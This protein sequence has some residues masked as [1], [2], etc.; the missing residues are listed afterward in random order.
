M[1]D[2]FLQSSESTECCRV[3]SASILWKALK[4]T[5]VTPASL[6]E[7]MLASR[8][9]YLPCACATCMFRVHATAHFIYYM[10]TKH[11]NVV[12][13][14]VCRLPQCNK[15]R[16][17]VP[18]TC[19]TRLCCTHMPCG[20]AACMWTSACAYVC[21]HKLRN[22]SDMWRGVCTRAYGHVYRHVYGRVHRQVYRHVYMHVHTNV[23]NM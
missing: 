1:V 18:Y 4:S 5:V 19:A 15:C 11:T 14:A 10:H 7:I 21:V 9:P 2:F 17:C 6:C 12:S 3:L 20:I 23:S 8:A 13:Q 16:M 22:I